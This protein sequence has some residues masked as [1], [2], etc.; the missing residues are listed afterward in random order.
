MRLAVA[1][2]ELAAEDGRVHLSCSI[3]VATLSPSSRSSWMVLLGQADA[4]AYL[5]KQQGRNRV[6]A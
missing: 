1:S 2:L 6:V 4:A 5:A 3:G